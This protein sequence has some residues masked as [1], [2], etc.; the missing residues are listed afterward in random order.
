MNDDIPL[1]IHN[2]SDKASHKTLQLTG[3]TY[4]GSKLCSDSTAVCARIIGESHL[5]LMYTFN[6]TGMSVVELSHV[7][8]CSASSVTPHATPQ[9]HNKMSLPGEGTHR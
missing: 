5:V 3:T 1:F 8:A 9:H 7:K 6:L 2:P 4:A